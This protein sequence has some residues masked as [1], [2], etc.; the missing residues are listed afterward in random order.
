[1]KKTLRDAGHLLR[2][3]IM[4]A[5]GTLLFLV[6]RQAVIPKGFGQ[7]GHFRPGALDDVRGR[8]LHFAGHEVC[9]GCH[10]DVAAKKSA[11]KHAGVACEACHGPQVKHANAD[12]PSAQ[13]PV[14]P[15][16]A[17]LCARCH[18]KNVAKPAKFPQQN[19][20]EHSGGMACKECHTAHSPKIG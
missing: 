14:L 9:A 3:L 5:A 11:G 8:A 7:Y 15:D 1:M 6:V 13:K 18:E 19:T 12:D 4:F 2:P 16:T 10:D 17:V 20:K